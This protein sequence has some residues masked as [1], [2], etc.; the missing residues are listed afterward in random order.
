MNLDGVSM[1]RCDLAI[2]TEYPS[3]AESQIASRRLAVVLPQVFNIVEA[4]V[5]AH[6][7]LEDLGTC[8]GADVRVSRAYH[9]LGTALNPENYGPSEAEG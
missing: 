1:L 8:E 6:E 9:A 5:R 2:M 7:D 4:A 3:E